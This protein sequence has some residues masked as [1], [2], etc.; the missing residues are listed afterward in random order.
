MVCFTDRF[1]AMKSSVHVVFAANAGYVMPL[2]VALASLVAHFDPARELVVHII[3]NDASAE[4]RENVQRSVEMNRTGPVEI[5]WYGFDASLLTGLPVT[6]RFSPEVYLRTIAPLLLPAECRRV[7]YLDCDVV[8][9]KNIA[10]LYDSTDD[11]ATIHAAQDMATPFVSS[12]FGVFDYRERGFAPELP[13]FNSGVLVFNLQKWRERDLTRVALDYL[14]KNGERVI[15]QDQGVLNA[16]F[17]GEWQPFDSR[18]NQG[19]DVLFYDLWQAAGH[20][21]EEW[22]QA[23]DDPYIIHFSGHKKPWQRGRRGPRYSF[24]YQYLQKTVF[25]DSI[26]HRPRLEDVLGFPAYYQ[27]WKWARKIPG[28]V[29]P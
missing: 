17:A 12:R 1:P 3:S 20:S 22:K 7:I 6:S 25:K 16:L 14:S 26:P 4:D 10:E 28:L 2:S 11:E 13:Y 8:V 5:H 15:A 18:W 24:F 21:R 27:L 19:F 29:K 9:L 23:L